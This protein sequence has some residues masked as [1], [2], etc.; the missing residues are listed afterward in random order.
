MRAAKLNNA[1][2]FDER[3]NRNLNETQ[4]ISC[5]DP[6]K[7]MRMNK[8][9]GTTKTT[10]YQRTPQDERQSGRSNDCDQKRMDGEVNHIL[11]RT[12]SSRCF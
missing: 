1:F 9:H 2:Q 6:K 3:L 4:T 5:D 10:T 8:M 11:G 12:V 7:Q